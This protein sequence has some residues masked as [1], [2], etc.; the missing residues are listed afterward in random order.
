MS[1]RTKYGK[2]FKLRV[3]TEV[4]EG[5]YTKEEARR[6]YKIK[7]KSSILYWIRLF[8]GKED[9]RK[10]DKGEVGT[11]ETMKSTM[12]LV[13]LQAKVKELEEAN[14]KA[15]QRADLWEMMV[16]IAEER[17]NIDIR[18]KSGVQPLKNTEKQNHKQK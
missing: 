3:V 12:K 8:I 9:I 10:A 5:I 11:F 7:G 14:R 18:K 13:A 15:E 2:A 17:L 1:K 4:I 16:E 6:K